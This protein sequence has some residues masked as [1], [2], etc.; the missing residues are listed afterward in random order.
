MISENIKPETSVSDYIKILELSNFIDNWEQTVLFSQNGF[1]TLKGKNVQGKTK[2][3]LE[4]LEKDT[5]K[6]LSEEDFEVQLSYQKAEKIK[7]N[8]IQTIKEKMLA[9]EKSEN[10]KYEIE[11]TEKAIEASKEKAI[12]YKNF[13]D[14]V[15]KCYLNALSAIGLKSELL[16]TSKEETNKIIKEFNSDFFEGITKSFIDENS[17]DSKKFYSQNKNYIL[18]EKQEN[19]EKAIEQQKEKQ[20]AFK[21]AKDLILKDINKT[22][23]FDIISK[24]PNE[25]IRKYT[26]IYF[27]GFYNSKENLEKE[28]KEKKNKETWEN[29]DS[30]LAQNSDTALSYVDLNGSENEINAQINYIKTMIKDGEIKTDN[31]KFFELYKAAFEETSKF[32]E[33][34][35]YNFKH[36]LNKEDFEFFLNLQKNIPEIK[37]E[38]YE[39]KQHFEKNEDF[40]THLIKTYNLEKKIYEKNANKQISLNQVAELIESIATRIKKWDLVRKRG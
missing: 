12:S 1:Y 23:A 35:L 33:T 17:E 13:P 4:V 38:Y 5:D 9:Y 36:C 11:T 28:E 40:N 25:R 34:D 20:L 30:G 32:S 19:L 3:L 37:N 39:L 29:I 31:K 2:E 24:T 22:K 14:T 26:Q 21:Q 27:E 16:Q 10:L 8:K 15:E 6:I 18:K 7:R